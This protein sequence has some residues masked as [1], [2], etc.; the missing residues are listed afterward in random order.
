[1]FFFLSLFPKGFVRQRHRNKMVRCFFAFSFVFIVVFTSFEHSFLEIEGNLR[2]IDDRCK[3]RR[4]DDDEDEEEEERRTCVHRSSILIR[5]FLLDLHQSIHLLPRQWIN[6]TTSFPSSS[7]TSIICI[8]EDINLQHI[9]SK[10][11]FRRRKRNQPSVAGK[12]FC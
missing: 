6:T 11:L 7:T 8:F 1:M 9:V 3:R 12:V 4:R 5:F 10:F 2:L